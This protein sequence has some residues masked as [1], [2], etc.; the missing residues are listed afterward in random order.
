MN[1]TGPE[2][3]PLPNTQEKVIRGVEAIAE[4]IFGDRTSRRKVYYLAEK[5]CIPIFRLGSTLCLRPPAC[6]RFIAGQKARARS[7][8][9]VPPILARRVH[10][11][12]RF[13]A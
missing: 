3:R 12:R 8:A 4:Y 10:T 1:H 7:Q 2:P 11:R 6:E 5:A 13:F 9:V